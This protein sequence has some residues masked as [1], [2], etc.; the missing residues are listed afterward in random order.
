[1]QVQENG[2]RKY[3]SEILSGVH[4][5]QKKNT[6]NLIYRMEIEKTSTCMKQHEEY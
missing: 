1:M 4:K 3:N 6:T 2:F 5:P